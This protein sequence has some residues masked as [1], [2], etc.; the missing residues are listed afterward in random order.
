MNVPR[1]RILIKHD[2]GDL[3][4]IFHYKSMDSCKQNRPYRNF[5][6]Q[7]FKMFT[8]N[9]QQY[10][11]GNRFNI[12]MRG[13]L[14][15][16]ALKVSNKSPFVNKIPCEI[17]NLL[18]LIQRPENSFLHKGNSLTYFPGFYKRLSFFYCHFLNSFS[19][20]QLVLRIQCS[21]FFDISKKLFHILISP[22]I[23]EI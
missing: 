3:Q 13:Q 15:C 10:S 12:F 11:I 16:K 7:N 8:V 22:R 2:T 14:I 6:F 20:Q 4:F 19:N 23:A 17:I 21:E 1:F 18:V 9:D 5:L